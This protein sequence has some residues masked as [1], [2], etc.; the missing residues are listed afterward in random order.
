MVRNCSS[1]DHRETLTGVKLSSWVYCPEFDDNGKLR[2]EGLEMPALLSQPM[3]VLSCEKMDDGHLVQWAG[4]EDGDALFIVFKGT[5]NP[6]DVLIDM[7]VLQSQHKSHG[8][9]VMSSM[10]T[11]LDHKGITSAESIVERISHLV[12]ESGKRR[13][14]LCGYSLGGGYAILA[15]LDMIYCG[16]SISSVVTFGAPQVVVPDHANFTWQRLNAITSLYVNAWD[17]VPRLPSCETWLFEVLPEVPKLLKS[18]R[19]GPLTICVNISEAIKKFLHHLGPLKLHMSGYDTVGTLYFLSSHESFAMRIKFDSDGGHRKQL[20]ATPVTPTKN[21]LEDHQCERYE[22]IIAKLEPPSDVPREG[23]EDTATSAVNE[24]VGG[25]VSSIHEATALS[26]MEPLPLQ[27][28]VIHD[29]NVDD[30]HVLPLPPP[31]SCASDSA[32]LPQKAS[33]SPAGL[34]SK[35]D[36]IKEALELDASLSI[37]ATLAKANAMMELNPNGSGLPSQADALLAALG[38]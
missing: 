29:D 5:D 35:I 6:T 26:A 24:A 9:G 31:P 14:V 19:I 21:V 8:L 1:I 10:Q 3:R 34:A 30:D 2:C 15:G 12:R 36:R 18:W 25:D 20:S 23:T 32:I 7:G 4:V 13:V 16:V 27:A 38:I 28:W 33:D 22:R 37:P 17:I 11:A